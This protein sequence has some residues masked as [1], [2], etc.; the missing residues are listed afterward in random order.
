M[1]RKF[2]PVNSAAVKSAAVFACVFS[3]LWSFNS[4][5][6]EEV[7]LAPDQFIAQTFSSEQP[8][9]QLL[10]ITG[11]LQTAARNILGKK[12][13][14]LRTR[15]WQQNGQ[16]AWILEEIGK[17]MPITVG[18]VV[19]DSKIAEL[20]VLVYR[21]TRGWEVRAPSFTA[22]FSGAA[23]KKKNKL[24]TRIDGISGATLS[25]NALQKLARLAL[26]YDS[27]LNKELASAQ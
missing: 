11:E 5:A 26:L 25:V 6:L 18:V 22:Q 4:H 27:A 21:E 16:S 24:D 19:K 3:A 2:G 20:K 17:D 13:D 7:Y 10:W 1:Y 15:Y 8:Q 23:L 9:A 14:S 12:P